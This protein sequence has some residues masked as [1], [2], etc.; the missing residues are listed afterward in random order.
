[1]VNHGNIHILTTCDEKKTSF[2]CF[3]LQIHNPSPYK[4]SDKP[5]LRGA[6][7]ISDQYSSKGQ[8]HNKQEG[9]AALGWRRAQHE[10]PGLDPETGE[11]INR[12][13]G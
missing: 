7:Q 1:M 13:T 8:S 4:T 3:F 10:Y 12:E 6:L 5:K 2:H 9:E 11:D